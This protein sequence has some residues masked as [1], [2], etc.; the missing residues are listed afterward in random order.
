MN[1]NSVQQVLRDS[2][3]ACKLIL[4]FLAY[5]ADVVVT[6]LPDFVP[7]MSGNIDLNK[8]VLSG[9]ATARTLIWWVDPHK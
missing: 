3:I 6:D 8:D 5:R 4:Y 7:L 1:G 9:S 2:S